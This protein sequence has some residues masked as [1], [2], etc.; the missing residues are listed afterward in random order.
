[1]SKE[2]LNLLQSYSWPGN[3]RELENIIE[4]ATILA[5]DGEI[6]IAQLPT[7]LTTDQVTPMALPQAGM[8]L[9]EV[10][11]LYIEHIFRETG[12]HKMR[13]SQILNIARR[14]LDRKLLQYNIHKDSAATE[15]E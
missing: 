6:D 7:K 8:P 4:M 9:E 15:T 5:D 10:E 13:T 2:A 11:R 12:G 3:V 1:L 14:T